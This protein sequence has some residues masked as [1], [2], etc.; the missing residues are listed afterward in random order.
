MIPMKKLMN[1]IKMNNKGFTLVELIVVIAII[2]IITVVVAPQYLGYVEKA[3]EA[4]D[5]NAAG[6]M[7]HA[8]EIAYIEASVDATLNGGTLNVGPSSHTYTYT[9]G[10]NTLESNFANICP[11]G[12]YTFV[13]KA[14]AK[15][16]TI[17]ITADGQAT[18]APAQ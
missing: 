3:K 5:E 8:A 4:T 12:S 13:S 17:T 10:T 14:Y 7:A 15:G 16:V 2:A 18:A 6:E 11:S 9:E 1:K